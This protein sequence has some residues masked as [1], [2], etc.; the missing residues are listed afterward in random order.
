VSDE[1]SKRLLNDGAAGS[2][3]E[4]VDQARRA[5]L[6]S[7]GKW[8]WAVIGAVAGTGLAISRQAEAGAWINRRGGWAN[9]GSV[10]VN[11]GGGSWGNSR[12]GGGGW[13][14]R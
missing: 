3:D 2:H 4:T 7:L 13:I 5:F 12:G 9:G 14:N 1:Q 8:S 10:W 6:G 11:G